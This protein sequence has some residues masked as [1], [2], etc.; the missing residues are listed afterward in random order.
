MD[1]R[2]A[3]S[4]LIHFYAVHLPAYTVYMAVSPMS[5]PAFY[6]FFCHPFLC[7]TIIILSQN[8]S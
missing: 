7:F 4:Y 8:L 6:L 2:P 1:T 3:S 5:L